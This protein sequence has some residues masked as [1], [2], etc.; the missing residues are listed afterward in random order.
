MK[1]WILYLVCI[2]LIVSGGYLSFSH[3][4]TSEYLSGL[5]KSS[6]KTNSQSPEVVVQQEISAP[7]L[8]PFQ[9]IPYTPTITLSQTKS[10]TSPPL[11]TQTPPPS[12][13]QLPYP[14]ATVTPTPFEVA[15]IKD[16]RGRWP[17]YNLNCEARSAV[18][19][20]AYFGVSID[21]VAFFNSLPVSDDPDLGFVG[22]VHEPWGQ[23][24]PN[25]YGVHAAPVAELLQ[26]YGLNAQPVRGMT[27]DTLRAEISQGRPVI[28]WVVGRVGRGTPIAY[29]SSVGRETVVARFEHTVILTGYSK[30][31]VTVLDGYWVYNR[32]IQDFSVSWDVLGNMA[33]ILSDSRVSE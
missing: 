12:S 19:W 16:I 20:A 18:D 4:N 8:T 31:E 25:G 9:P 14:T 33:V 5:F 28:V 11:S 32:P 13:T 24:P 2:V 17:A 29:T 15:S 23:T 1:R 6:G 21:E 27:W 26:E 7:T 10:A 30:T 22:S 3:S